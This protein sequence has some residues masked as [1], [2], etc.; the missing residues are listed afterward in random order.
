MFKPTRRIPSPLPYWAS[1]QHR[2]YRYMLDPLGVSL[3][4]RISDRRWDQV[5]RLSGL[6]LMAL[7]GPR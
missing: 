1:P 6:C 3:R 4:S 2:V 7:Y 5:Y